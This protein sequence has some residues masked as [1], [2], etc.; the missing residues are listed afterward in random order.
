MTSTRR[1]LII[2]AGSLGLVAVTAT[3]ASAGLSTVNHCLPPTR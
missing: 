2:I 3:S 1:F